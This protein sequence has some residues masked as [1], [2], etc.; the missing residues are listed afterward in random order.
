MQTGSAGLSKHHATPFAPS[1]GHIL[2]TLCC[3]KRRRISH[4]LGQPKAG[5]RSVASIMQSRAS[6][7]ADMDDLYGQGPEKALEMIS[8]FHTRMERE[9]RWGDMSSVANL[10]AKRMHRRG[11]L[12]MARWITRPPRPCADAACIT[13]VKTPAACM[14]TSPSNATVEEPAVCLLRRRCKLDIVF[15]TSVVTKMV[16]AGLY[17][18][19]AMRNKALQ[20]SQT[21]VRVCSG[22]GRK[23]QARGLGCCWWVAGCMLCSWLDANLPCLPTHTLCLQPCRTPMW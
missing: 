14:P 3:S 11:R 16:E 7:L 21:E 6:P 20:L 18:V 2:R 9:G 19:N 23:Q 15:A 13:V 10:K 22:S 17:P 4:W 8:E 5:C 12:D 1:D